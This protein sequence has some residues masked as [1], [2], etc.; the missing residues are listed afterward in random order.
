MKKQILTAIIAGMLLVANGSPALAAGIDLNGVYRDAEQAIINQQPLDE[1]QIRQRGEEYTSVF[2]TAF[3]QLSQDYEQSFRQGVSDGLKGSPS[4]QTR[5]RVGQAG[6]QRGYRRGQQLR[7][8]PQPSQPDPPTTA[9]A[10]TSVAAVPAE[11]APAQLVSGPDQQEYPAQEPSPDQAKFI[12]RVAKSA[13]KVGMEYDLYPSVI[14]AQAALESNWGSSEL[15]RK[16]Y[17][18]LFGVKGSFNGKSV[19]QPTTEYTHDGHEQKINDCFRWYENDYQS[20]CDYA[21]TL[22]DPLYAGVHRG[23]AGNYRSAT[24][25]LLGRY[26]TDPQYDRKLN[27]IIASYGL[28]KYDADLPAGKANRGDQK[29]QTQQPVA[30]VRGQQATGLHKRTHHLTWLSIVGGAGSAGA[31]GLLRR[32]LIKA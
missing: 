5:S 12:S 16:P 14:I 31:L 24:H 18:N 1:G 32:F 28:T 22:A 11:Q 27:K 25:A 29:S 8:Q 26:A 9:H 2:L 13:Q 3:S 17:H 20:L 7:P 10:D 21:E 4:Q 30:T 23:Q 19:L 15:A 6:Y